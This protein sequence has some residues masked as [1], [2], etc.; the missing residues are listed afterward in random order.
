MSDNDDRAD[1]ARDDRGLEDEQRDEQDERENARA[2]FPHLAPGV[3]PR[4]SDEHPTF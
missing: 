1:E 3:K 4:E 2:Y